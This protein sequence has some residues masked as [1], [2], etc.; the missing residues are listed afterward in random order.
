[1]PKSHEIC[2]CAKHSN[3]QATNAHEKGR[4]TR[5]YKSAFL[6]EKEA[7]NKAYDYILSRGLLEDFRAYSEEVE[8]GFLDAHT[9]VIIRL[10]AF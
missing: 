4:K 10:A 7:K 3:A 6:I 1:M 9:R 2:R 5:S 8:L